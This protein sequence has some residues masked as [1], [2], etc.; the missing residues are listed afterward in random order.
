MGVIVSLRRRRA[1]GARGCGGFPKFQSSPGNSLDVPVIL[2][3]LQALTIQTPPEA[4]NT[5]GW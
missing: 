3:P 2:L 1:L 4:V 5:I